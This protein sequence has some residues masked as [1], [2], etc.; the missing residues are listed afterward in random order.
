MAAHD[1][2]LLGVILWPRRRGS[3]LH[4][5]LAGARAS[6]LLRRADLDVLALAPRGGG[7]AEADARRARAGHG[8][9][10]HEGL[11][12]RRR[13]RAH[14]RVRRAARAD[15]HPQVD[16]RAP[17][18]D[19]DL[20]VR[21]CRCQIGG[22]GGRG[23]EVARHLH[24]DLQHDG[25]AP[26]R[27]RGR[28]R[29]LGRPRGRR[30]EGLAPGGVV[31]AVAVGEGRAVVGVALLRAAPLGVLPANLAAVLVAP[32]VHRLLADPRGHGPGPAVPS[33]HDG[34]VGVRPHLLRVDLDECFPHRD[35]QRQRRRVG[36]VRPVGP[37][38]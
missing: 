32:V 18:L 7:G 3:L 10:H 4:G 5:L 20:L 26:P 13:E 28:R 6:G 12:G 25:P 31:A 11:V 16:D 1:G 23:L 22:L 33:V 21:D 34:V 14:G 24:G 17:P 29:S 36:G 37:A 8:R 15:D 38:R 9:V 27:F 30:H 2:A 19:A 35:L